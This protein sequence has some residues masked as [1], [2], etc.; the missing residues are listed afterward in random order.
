MYLSE[1][2]KHPVPLHAN[3]ADHALDVVHTDFISDAEARAKHVADLAMKWMVY[4]SEHPNEHAVKRN[5][6]G[7]WCSE[8][9][10]DGDCTTTGSPKKSRKNGGSQR[11]YLGVMSRGW[12]QTVI[13]MERNM[14]NYSRNLLAYGVRLG[15]YREL[16]FPGKELI[17]LK[18]MYIEVGMGILL[19]TVWVNLAQTSAKIVSSR[20]FPHYREMSLTFHLP[21]FFYRT[22]GSPCTS[23]PLR[24]SGSCLLPASPL[25]SKNARSSSENA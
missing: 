24:S 20:L 22:T 7:A 14:L 18:L 9:Q 23:S 8:E 6:T 17:L 11:G 10:K 2:L 19:A 12:H 1:G 13:L 25:S 16:L 3:P 15:M 21:P 5:M 4:A